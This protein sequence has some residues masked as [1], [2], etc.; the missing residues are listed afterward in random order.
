M[1]PAERV[2]IA[3]R[4]KELREERGLTRQQL[5]NAL[6]ISLT[7]VAGYEQGYRVPKFDI[8]QDLSKF[9]RVPI[10]YLVGGVREKGTVSVNNIQITDTLLADFVTK[11][12]VAIEGAEIT[13]Q[14]KRRNLDLLLGMLETLI[15]Q[16]G[17]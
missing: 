16:G 8:L 6:N 4:I 17:D 13:P 1:R 15:R 3:E 12:S 9:F 2:I 5:A 7:A 14:Q 11:V 10:E